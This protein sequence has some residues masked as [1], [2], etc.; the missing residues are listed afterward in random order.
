MMRDI[1]VCEGIRRLVRAAGLLA[2]VFVPPAYAQEVEC[3]ELPAYVTLGSDGSV[4]LTPDSAARWARERN[5][6]ILIQQQSIPEAEGQLRQAEAADNLSVDLSATAIRMGPVSTIQ[7]PGAEGEEPMEVQVGQEEAYQATISANL[8]IYTG[9][10]VGI[11]EDIAREGIEAARQGVETA[12]LQVAQG[13]R[14][15]SYGVLRSVQLA[16]VAAAQVTAIAEHVR[17]AELLEEAGVVAHFDVVQA[18]TE[19]ARANEQLIVV[20]TAV[21]QAKAQLRDILALP[22]GLAITVADAPSPPMPDDDVASLIE[23]A[24]ICRP[25]IRSAETSL[26]MARLSLR[27]AEKELAPTV[28]LTGQYARQSAGGLGGTD[29]SWQ[30]GIVAQKPIFDGGARDGR[31]ESTQARVAAAELS[32]E[33]A[34]EQV[35][36]DVMLA[37]LR[38]Q[39]AQERILSAEQGLVEAREWRRMAQLRYREGLAAG[40]EVIDADTA[41]AA[42]EASLVNAE[43]DRQLAVTQLRTAMGLSDQMQQEVETQ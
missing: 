40:I 5:T 22:Q 8:P 24:R 38:V 30:V 12:Q 36:L 34:T 25:E 11:G 26:R 23:T 43:Y 14:Q 17:N 6:Q 18:R 20:Q 41:L 27:L 33:R 32:V 13:A 39:E 29:W 3:P 10:R 42:A 2:V 21:E 19:L 35:S 28:A 37:W 16:G 1:G 15:I 4:V 7:L 9:G 31:V